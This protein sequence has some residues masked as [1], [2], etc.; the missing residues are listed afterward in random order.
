MW[1]HQEET[2]TRSRRRGSL[3]DDPD[4]IAR[5]QW[6]S[7]LRSDVLGKIKKKEDDELAKLDDN[8]QRI[9]T[10]PLPDIDDE[11]KVTPV[12]EFNGGFAMLLSESST[13][14]EEKSDMAE[15]K[16]HYD[17]DDDDDDNRITLT[18]PKP[19]ISLD[20]NALKWLLRF[21]PPIETGLIRSRLICF[22]GLGGSAQSFRH[23]GKLFLDDNVEVFGVCL[24]G[25]SNATVKPLGSSIDDLM[26]PLFDSLLSHGIVSSDIGYR[27]P[28]LIFFAHSVGCYVAFELARFLRRKGYENL[29]SSLVVSSSKA[30][31]VIS[32]YN[33]DKWNRFYFLDS[34]NDLI[35]RIEVLGGLPSAVKERHDLLSVILSTVRNDHQLM[36]KY[37]FKT[38]STEPSKPLKCSIVTI[39]TDDDESMTLEELAAWS[40][41]S[42]GKHVQHVFRKGGHCYLTIPEYEAIV[43]DGLKQLVDNGHVEKLSELGQ[44]VP[45]YPVIE[46][47]P[48]NDDDYDDDDD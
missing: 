14:I 26:K 37:K 40:T 25:R 22:H 44:V 10:P 45:P 18:P 34:A 38:I 15:Q 27:V 42:T 2:V 41:Q 5:R 47:E 39:A 6:Y 36:E 8:G 19:S 11:L 32:E 17:D 21:S 43:V 30:P 12:K 20:T 35:S 23:W 46:K 16:S 28:K 13:L 31:Q 1:D 7:N 9:P 33:S 24:P 48:E 3:S 29:V 4:V